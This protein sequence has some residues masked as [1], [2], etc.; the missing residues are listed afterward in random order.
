M[1]IPI[2]KLEYL[3][4][5]SRNGD[6]E[7]YPFLAYGVIYSDIISQTFHRDLPSQTSSQ[8]KQAVSS[9]GHFVSLL[10]SPENISPK[11][12]DADYPE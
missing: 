9:P 1:Y 6:Y 8:Q 7:G 2:M 4:R 12:S 5:L 10:A 3:I 11:R